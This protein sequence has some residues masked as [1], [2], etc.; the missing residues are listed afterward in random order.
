VFVSA[1]F[2]GV[3][4]FASARRITFL[5]DNA[6]GVAHFRNVTEKNSRENANIDPGFCS[7]SSP[8]LFSSPLFFFLGSP[9]IRDAFY[10]S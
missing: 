1:S 10:P 5:L 9:E 7:E 2:V 4:F 3:R 6:T 8:M